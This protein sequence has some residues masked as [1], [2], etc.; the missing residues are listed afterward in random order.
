MPTSILKIQLD[1]EGILKARPNRFLGIVDIL[2]AKGKTVIIENEK[3]HI[4]D[5]GRLKEILYPGNRVLLKKAVERSLPT[6]K[7]GWDL[8][9]GF[10]ADQWVLVHSGFHRQITEVVLKKKLLQFLEE[11]DSFTPE[12]QFG[13]SRLD[14]LLTNKDGSQTFIEVKGCTLNIAGRALFPDAPTLRGS[15]HLNALVEATKKGYE[16]AIIVLVF[17]SDSTCFA[18]NEETDPKFT[19]N[20]KEAVK[21][22]VSVYPLL[23]SFNKDTG[24]IYFEKTIPVCPEIV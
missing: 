3:V 7:T 2:D 13:H 10:V 18:P 23:M 1:A 17:R 24:R 19:E 22:G 16:A 4:H 5:P 15:K 12:V 21:N 11:M 20:F 14:F 9:S 6:R 8:I